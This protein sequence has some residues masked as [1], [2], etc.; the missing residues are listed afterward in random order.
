M[1]KAPLFSFH[2]FI[3]RRSHLLPDQ[4]PGEHSGLPPQVGQCL[5][6]FAFRATHL[7]I[8][9]THTLISSRQKYDGWAYSEVHMCSLMCTNHIDMTA[10]TA[11]F[12]Y[13]V[14]YHSY[15]YGVQ[16]SWA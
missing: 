2:F 8:S 4:L 11:A 16:H 15:I 9:Q 13:Q 7:L 6:L 1:A 5:P 3:L 14:V 12:F 10:C